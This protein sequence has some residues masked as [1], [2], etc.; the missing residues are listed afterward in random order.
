MTEQDKLRRILETDRVWCAYALADLDPAYA[1]NCEWLVG[2]DSVVL[3][4]Q[5]MEPA[6][7]FAHGEPVQV[8]EL[9]QRVPGGRYQFG[10]MATH[11]SLVADRLHPETETKMWRMALKPDRFPGGGEAAEALGSQHLEAVQSLIAGH[12][13][14]PDAFSADQLE[15]GEFYGLRVDEQLVAIAGTHVIS[16]TMDVAAVGNVFTHPMQRGQGYGREASAAVVRALLARG[17][18]TI[19]LNVAMD[20]TPAL[21]VYERLGFF[22]FC[23]YYEGVAQLAPQPTTTQLNSME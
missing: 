6:V 18:G 20:N 4:Y 9:L 1:A 10:F 22:P 3:I 5:G 11:R 8:A 21:R 23:G 14:R 15:R 2:D 17:F 13:D 12:P 7:L 19:V 16:E